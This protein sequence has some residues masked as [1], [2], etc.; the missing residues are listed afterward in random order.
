M[1]RKDYQ[2]PTMRIVQMRHRCQIMATSYTTTSY[3][4]TTGLNAMDDDEILGDG[5]QSGGNSLSGMGADVDL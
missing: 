2:K 1:K 3:T 5:A 4:T